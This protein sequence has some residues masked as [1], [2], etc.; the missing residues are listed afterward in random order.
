MSG[1]YRLNALFTGLVGE[2][3]YAKPKGRITVILKCIVI[4]INR[5]QISH[6]TPPSESVILA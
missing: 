1:I 2:A 5:F 6:L 3:I 4:P